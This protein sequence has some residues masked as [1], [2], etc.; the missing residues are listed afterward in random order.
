MTI[1][2]MVSLLFRISFFNKITANRKVDCE[3]L[4]VSGNLYFQDTLCRL[5]AAEE[6]TPAY[7]L[8]NKPCAVQIILGHVLGHT[9]SSCR[10]LA[11]LP[12]SYMNREQDLNPPDSK[13][14]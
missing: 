13:A 10:A 8:Y 1:K 5:T 2:K 9:V 6:Q 7:M 3:V 12:G 14:K 4:R 11:R